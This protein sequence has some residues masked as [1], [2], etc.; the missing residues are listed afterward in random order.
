MTRLLVLSGGGTTS[1][2]ALGGTSNNATPEGMKDRAR[3]V[4]HALVNSTYESYGLEAVMKEL[5]LSFGVSSTALKRKECNRVLG[6]V[7][8][9]GGI[10]KEDGLLDFEKIFSTG[11][12]DGKAKKKSSKKKHA[13][14][15]IELGAGFGE[16]IVN[17]ASE[18]PNRNHVA[19]ELRADR[20][21]QIFARTAICSGTTNLENLC[22]VGGEATDFLASYVRAES[23]STIFINHPEPPTQT[24]GAEQENLGHIMKGGEE[25]AH[26]LNS[27]MFKEAIKCL[28]SGG[29]IVVVTDNRWYGKLICATL[30]RVM[31]Q[32][33]GTIH[34]LD[35]SESMSAIETFG[36]EK[37]AIVRLYEGTPGESIGHSISG[38]RTGISYFDRL[39]RTGAGRHS[40]RRTRYVIAVSKS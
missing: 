30:S 7:G 20:V 24:F 13:P 22:V 25:P 19:V 15:D 21:G 27:R 35:L 40:E 16:W 38:G 5:G 32:N 2:S 17:Q 31:S 9:Q 12:T 3:S 37:E 39:W 34:D 1:L 8:L 33:S 23:I 28:S 6:M 29:K 26:M 14:V 18:N 4:Q 11:L 10:V 36:E